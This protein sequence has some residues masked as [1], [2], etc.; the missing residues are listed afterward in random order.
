MKGRRKDQAALRLMI[1]LAVAAVTIAGSDSITR[2]AAATEHAL[3]SNPGR[4]IH[5]E[6][7]PPATIALSGRFEAEDYRDGGE[8][9]GYS[10]MSALNLG[11]EYR[12]DAVDIQTTHDTSGDYNIGWI[13]AGE[14]LAYDVEVDASG[15][16]VFSARVATIYD[17]RSVQ[18][19]HIELD[20]TNV[21]GP[22][23]AP[24]TGGWQ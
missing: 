17:C 14:W 21:T 7:R 11:G 19:F 4:L 6:V 3:V 12:T 18:R 5:T 10:D 13:G 16:Y 15:D 24:N 22:I 9:I 8:G 23:A 20:G 1:L 2:A